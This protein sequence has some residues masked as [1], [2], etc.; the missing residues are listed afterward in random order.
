[1]L[2]CCSSSAI[3]SHHMVPYSTFFFQFAT[4]FSHSL[5]VFMLF[6]ISTCAAFSHHPLC[7]ILTYPYESWN[8]RRE[9]KGFFVPVCWF[10]LMLPLRR[11]DK[12]AEMLL[13][14]FSFGFQ[15]R[16]GPN[17]SSS[18]CACS[19]A[20]NK[21][22]VSK[23]ER[24]HLACVPPSSPSSSG[25][26]SNAC[27]H[28]CAPDVPL[29]RDSQRSPQ[30]TVT[31]LFFTTTARQ[32]APFNLRNHHAHALHRIHGALFHNSAQSGPPV[33]RRLPSESSIRNLDLRQ[34]GDWLAEGP[35]RGGPVHLDRGPTPHGPF[36]WLVWC[37]GCRGSFLG[38]RAPDRLTPRRELRTALESLPW[39]SSCWRHFL[40][41]ACA[42]IWVP[43]NEFSMPRFVYAYLG[44][45]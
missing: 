34:A 8:P 9:L 44:A 35:G 17:S 10:S 27:L 12:G 13:S 7:Q 1:M 25:N 30:T 42:N 4:Y 37:L 3:R 31:Q 21:H 45:R 20:L 39:F 23:S 2:L 33:P 40:F 15:P 32:S 19:A 22:I 5:Q 14:L 18:R 26:A 6:L 41:L 38:R 29:G 36:L 11:F 28:H 16:H 24:D 43:G